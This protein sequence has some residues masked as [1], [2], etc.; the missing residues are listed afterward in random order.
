MVAVSAAI[1]VVVVLAMGI[2]WA[3]SR[4]SAVTTYSVSSPLRQVDLKLASGQA[5]IVGSSAP[6]LQVRRT[7]VYSF[8]HPAR[9]R[10]WFAGGVLHI[11]S[12]CPATVLGTC[13]ASYELA[14]P[15]AVTIR[16]ETRAGDIR[17][18]GF[19]G[20]ASVSTGSGSLDVEAYC[21][22]HLSARS[23]SGNVHVATACAPQSLSVV[24]GSG[25]AVALVPPGHYRVAASS[26]V[27]RRTVDGVVDDPAAPFTI[28]A[29]SSTG[30]VSVEGGL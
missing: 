8:G 18:T 26:G 14:V 6:A 21:G 29:A 1:V 12:G 3:A 5:V 17:I 2:G 11:H 24:S 13:S 23:G 25:D 7:D 9:E 16:V 30:S 27:G 22:F 28:Q 10:R 15:E 20:N 19:N 4:Q